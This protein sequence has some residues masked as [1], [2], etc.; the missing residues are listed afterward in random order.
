[1]SRR[2]FIPEKLQHG[3]F[4]R[5]QALAAGLTSRQLQG[6]HFLQVF[7][8]VWVWVGYEMTPNDVIEAAGMSLPPDARV[9]HLSR[10]QLLGFHDGPLRP[11]H[12]LIARDHH[13]AIEDITL[14]RTVA[15]PPLDGIGVS[16]A[17]AFIGHCATARVIDLIA[18]GDWLLNRG[19]MTHPEL[20][21][22]AFHHLWRP[23]AREALRVS[24]HLNGRSRSPKESELR[25]LLVF[26]GLPEPEVN[27][28]LLDD[29]HTPWTD[30]LYRRWR[31]AVEYEGS[32]HLIDRKQYNTDIARYAWMRDTSTE[33]IQVTKE[34]MR[35]QRAVVLRVHHKLAER[36]YDG[37]VPEFGRRWRSLFAPVHLRG[38]DLATP[39][40]QTRPR[41]VA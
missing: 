35:Q 7:P 23:G 15:M 16:P 41:S 36:G 1:M 24:P 39:F 34:M 29:P 25:A 30:L 31:L 19:H 20:R 21:E 32:Q 26:A 14:H 4:T 27:P 18:I 33:Y 2:P 9:S 40:G 10:L 12:F 5:Q 37:P 11:I 28:P 22:L 3:P 6:K 13:I 8:R 17:A 38:G